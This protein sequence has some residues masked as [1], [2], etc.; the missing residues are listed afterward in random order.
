MPAPVWS[1]FI[2]DPAAFAIDELDAFTCDA[3]A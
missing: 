1:A 3:A 2:E